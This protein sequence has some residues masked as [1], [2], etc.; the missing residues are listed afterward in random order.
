MCFVREVPEWEGWRSEHMKKGECS[1]LN[2]RKRHSLFKTFMWTG[3]GNLW[4]YFYEIE[5]VCSVV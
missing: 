3:P 2:T 1:V 5:N 4:D